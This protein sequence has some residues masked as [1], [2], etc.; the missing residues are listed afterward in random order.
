MVKNLP[1]NAGDARNMSLISGSRRSPG[2]RNGNPIQYSFLG[3]PMDR[4]AWL[5]YSPWSGKEWGHDLVTK[6]NK[7]TTKIK[8]IRLF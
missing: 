7:T 3:N 4:G 6:T 2:E 8:T 1:P 5:G